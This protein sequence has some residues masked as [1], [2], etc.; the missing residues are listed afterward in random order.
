[1]DNHD[2]N[3][4]T[5]R[6]LVAGEFIAF[7][8]ALMDRVKLAAPVG[9][10]LAAI[11]CIGLWY[12]TEPKYRCQATLRISESRPHLAFPTDEK[13]KSF[14]ETQVELLRNPFIVG[15]AVDTERLSSLLPELRDI[16]GKEDAVRW[17]TERLKIARV[18][19]SDLYEV[20]FATRYPESAKAVV[21]AIVKTYMNYHEME[22]DHQ[23]HRMLDLLTA[24]QAVRDSD[25]ELKR[26]KLRDM[27][28]QAGGED[29]VVMS[30]HGGGGAPRSAGR[31]ALMAALQQKL[32]EA[33]V[34]IE[35]ARGRLLALRAETDEAVRV[36]VSQ[37]EAGSADDPAV[38]TLK[39]AKTDLMI[40]EKIAD[41]LRKKIE[42]ERGE[43]I[44]HGD[45][46]LELQFAQEELN[47]AE[48][49]RR[50]IAERAMHLT[51]ESRAPSQVIP[52]QMAKVPEF[53]EGPTLAAPLAVVAGTAFLAPLLLLFAWDLLHLRSRARA[54][55][56]RFDD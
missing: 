2:S 52:V 23:R 56:T 51:I 12:F 14:I 22:S 34:E 54:A 9:F 39:R 53:P 47:N 24:E 8:R 31:I 42:F 17:I 55:T 35:M 29:A 30:L 44:G 11:G 43:Q 32:I 13:N 46:S 49:V 38:A 41:T 27:T 20:S 19:Q 33:E 26:Q 21:N 36:P 5:Y 40:Q 7:W 6:A 3:T 48:E 16:V 1:M 37:V 28:Q 50:R 15:Q 10:V 25:I 45:K 18:S 4:Q